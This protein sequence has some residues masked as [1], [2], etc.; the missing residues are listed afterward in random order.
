MT[1]AATVSI[2]PAQTDTFAP[3]DAW[4]TTSPLKVFGEPI[5]TVSPP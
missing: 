1:L 2:P 5:V 3:F 4:K